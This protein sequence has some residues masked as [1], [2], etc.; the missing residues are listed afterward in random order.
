MLHPVV[1]P[2]GWEPTIANPA[3]LTTPNP[4]HHNQ[5]RT[6]LRRIAMTNGATTL[7][8]PQ[9]SSGTSQVQAGSGVRPSVLM[10]WRLTGGSDD[11]GAA[12]LRC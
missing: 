12:L 9:D 8:I 3:M 5:E 4:A 7:A 6:V 11:S 10:A 2:S 1:D